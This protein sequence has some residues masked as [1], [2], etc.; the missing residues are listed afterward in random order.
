MLKRTARSTLKEAEWRTAKYEHCMFLT[1]PMSKA[2]GPVLTGVA[3]MIKF[4]SPF[5]NRLE[6]VFSDFKQVNTIE[7]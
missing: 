3:N 2:E 4:L 5:L 7:S 6:V 1:K